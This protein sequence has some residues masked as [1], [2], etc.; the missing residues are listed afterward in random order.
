KEQTRI[1]E[2]DHNRCERPKG[3]SQPV[4][5]PCHKSKKRRVEETR[6]A[7]EC[8]QI[9]KHVSKKHPGYAVDHFGEGKGRGV[10]IPVFVDVLL[11]KGFR[12]VPG[13]DAVKNV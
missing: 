6:S 11:R 9:A 5:M 2:E 10:A 1:D 12:E 13:R 4:R 7:S 8:G 3:S